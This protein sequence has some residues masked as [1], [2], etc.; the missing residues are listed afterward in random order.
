MKQLRIKVQ[1]VSNR[2]GYHYELE[3]GEWYDAADINYGNSPC[4]KIYWGSGESDYAFY[5]RELFIS[6][7]E[8]R[9]LTLEK[10]GI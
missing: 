8:K 6:I 3:P 5:D 9:E 10:L 1:C 7:E 4:Y 2:C